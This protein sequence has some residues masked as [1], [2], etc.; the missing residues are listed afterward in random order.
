MKTYSSASNN[1]N[2][3]QGNPDPQTGLYTFSYPLFNIAAAYGF[4]PSL[5]LFLSFS[6]LNSFDSIPSNPTGCGRG[7]HIPFA[8]YSA[9][10]KTLTLSN[11][12]TYSVLDA[13]RY[14]AWKLSHK[15]KDL[16]VWSDTDYVYIKNA[17]GSKET[18]RIDHNDSGNAYLSSITSAAGRSLV[19][20]LNTN[21]TLDQ[22]L[23]G[24]SVLFQA[25]YRSQS[26]E[27]TSLGR[28]VSLTFSDIYNY[29]LTSINGVDGADITF[30]Y[31]R[32]DSN[33]P[34]YLTRTNHESGTVENMTYGN[35]LDTP[36]LGTVQ[37]IKA[38]SE[39]KIT[40]SNSEISGSLSNHT[41]TTYFSYPAPPNS[42]WGGGASGIIWSDPGDNLAEIEGKYEYVAQT[43]LDNLVTTYVY[44]KFHQ[45]IIKTIARNNINDYQV[46]FV[47]RYYGDD[48]KPLSTQ[49]CKYE[50]PASEELIISGPNGKEK[51]FNKEYEF[52]DYGNL[53]K[54]V[55]YNGI[56]TSN[57]YF[58][59]GGR[60][61]LCPPHPF[62]D[63]CAYIESSTVYPAGGFP[64]ATD[65]K[66]TTY[67]YQ[68]I[69]SDGL[70]VV[71][72]SIQYGPYKLV[73]T[74]HPSSLPQGEIKT[75]TLTVKGQDDVGGKPKENTVSIDYE[76]DETSVT[77]KST[78]AAYDGC[79]AI[80]IQKKHRFTGM[81]LEEIA[82]DGI[83]S[84]YEYDELDRLTQIVEAADSDYESV[85]TYQYEY[86]PNVN[87]IPLGISTIGERIS[88][89][90]NG[91]TT[92]VYQ[93][94]FDNE[95]ATYH[96]ENNM[97]Y[98]ISQNTYDNQIRLI[99]QEQ[100]DYNLGSINSRSYVKTDYSYGIWNEVCQ[101][102][103]SDETR[104]IRQVDPFSLS[105]TEHIERDLPNG[106]V[107][108]LPAS[109]IVT[110]LF[111]NPINQSI[112][113]KTGTVYSEKT[114]SYD[115]WGRLILQTTPFNRQM[116][117]AAYDLFGRPLETIHTDGTHF[118]TQYH[119]WT[120]SSLPTSLK[121]IMGTTEVELGT[122]AYD[123]LNRLTQ[124]VVDG[125]T[126]RREYDRVKVSAMPAK[127]INGRQ[128]AIDYML[129]PELGTYSKV[130][131]EGEASIF[132]F[133]SKQSIP[134]GLP[135]GLLI[136]ATNSEGTYTPT[137]TSTGRLA[138]IRQQVNG[139]QLKTTT[140][141]TQTLRGEILKVKVSNRSGGFDT[142][143][144]SLDSLGR[145]RA[146]EHSYGNIIVSGEYTRDEFGRVSKVTVKEGDDVRQETTLTY[147]DYGREQ[148]RTIKS[149][150][151]NHVTTI[152]CTYDIES[153]L[154]TRETSTTVANEKLI[155]HFSYDEKNRLTL[156]E[157][158]PTSS[159]SLLPCDERGKQIKKLVFSF[160]GLD[161]LEQL[162][163]TYAN[164]EED[165]AI[166]TYTGQQLRFINHSLTVGDNAHLLRVSLVYDLDGNLTSTSLPEVR[167]LQYS[168]F[169]QP[170]RYGLISY[171]YDAFGRILKTGN[172]I[173]Y[174]LGKK[175][176]SEV[177]GDNETLFAF[178]GGGS[179][180]EVTGDQTCWLGTDSSGTVCGT[181]VANNTEVS[182]YSPYGAGQGRSR[183][184]YNGERKDIAS[185]GYMLG[186]GTRLY[187]PGFAGFTSQ[188]SLSPFGAGGINPYRYC[189]GD[190]INLADPS[191]HMS[192]GARIGL[193]IGNIA[194]GIATA[195]MSVA[196]QIGI[197]LAVSATVAGL[198]MAVSKNSAQGESRT[199][200]GGGGGGSAAAVAVGVVSAVVGG[201]AGGAMGKK[202]KP[203]KGVA[204]SGSALRDE[205]RRGNN[206]PEE[207]W[208]PNEYSMNG[209]WDTL[210]IQGTG[211][212]SDRLGERGN[213]VVRGSPSWTA[214][215][216]GRTVA[217][218][219]LR[220]DSVVTGERGVLFISGTHGR[221]DG[222]N[223]DV[224]GRRRSQLLDFE[225]YACD[226]KFMLDD[227][228]M[229]NAAKNGA[230]FMWNMSE[231][232]SIEDLGRY[233]LSNEWHVVLSF[234][235]GSN[236]AAVRYFSELRRKV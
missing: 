181:T 49:G 103:Y 222:N 95:L 236:D 139:E 70:N 217:K 26:V 143:T 29:Y 18:L 71:I 86:L 173:N 50:L 166:Y 123:G 209:N 69:G 25:N 228:E 37:E 17:D 204:T 15:V 172:T 42:F 48:D 171:K 100:W 134:A 40:L 192:V 141:E 91:I 159:A 30:E 84:K 31:Y 230:L 21:N 68:T 213:T 225:F 62:G 114:A 101:E 229:K 124:T 200:G 10:A 3:L 190:P 52:D 56:T 215:N 6:P 151:T 165:T 79:Q 175:V 212:V 164:N 224:N 14:A 205:T 211:Y 198:S 108:K 76:F 109:R 72:D 23:E 33:G 140:V 34:C 85:T 131:A 235:Y 199:A 35:T 120:Q 63:L 203:K 167:N 80:Q 115:G 163:S 116:R 106:S 193:F 94:L 208:L 146:T 197:N 185:G 184:G 155:E 201:L 39:Y 207:A 196:A 138:T 149:C 129:V 19:V 93:D 150:I 88:V 206:L 195:G 81:L 183:T 83:K 142:V 44:N 16:Q 130:E 177:S 233:I 54:F 74:Y 45:C 154:T 111:G 2:Q 174:Y 188:D 180:A 117:V 43:T 58:P 67:T 234:C 105:I 110:D 24:D 220:R 57:I 7:W 157:V 176:F 137:Y 92:Q 38:L 60:E 132:S 32:P 28:S 89:T 107:S 122:Q 11:G 210:E 77:Q 99:S 153:K 219:L 221:R 223:W 5:S 20:K 4:G 182:S 218:E 90:K 96:V 135:P 97:S 36:F 144:W 13:D 156:Y 170:T 147:D 8:N 128:Q 227:P 187:L 121:G 191:G 231:G 75:V 87:N 145:L 64:N 73:Y 82:P 126:R 133:T 162:V 22:I 53:I 55:D 226:E 160:N 118:R 232:W 136:S 148:V 158:D 66:C 65:S 113:T 46:C 179:I 47:Y 41:L 51:R 78:I 127:A 112:L 27:F 214:A 125:V 98:K 168:P 178:H 12:Q 216:E 161:N 186:N 202:S 119:P 189:L 102:S 1:S 194:L 9:T 104:L 152:A 59:A 169:N 61:G